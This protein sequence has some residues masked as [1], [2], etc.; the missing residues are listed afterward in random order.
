MVWFCATGCTKIRENF[1]PDTLKKRHIEP[2]DFR[3]ADPTYVN[4]RPT[5]V[6]EAINKFHRQKGLG[7]PPHL[8]PEVFV[9]CAANL[10][11]AELQKFQ[12]WLVNPQGPRS[13]AGPLYEPCPETEAERIKL[14]EEADARDGK[15]L[16]QADP[17][18]VGKGLEEALQVG[19]KVT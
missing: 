12:E 10:P 16:L 4:F 6:E 5:S 18:P 3:K 9:D 14:A 1:V 13:T 17:E 11:L 7:V 8:W 19:P 15:L 2:M